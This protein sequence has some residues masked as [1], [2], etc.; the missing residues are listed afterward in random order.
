MNDSINYG[1]M[2]YPETPVNLPANQ[3]KAEYGSD[4]MADMLSAMGFKHIFLLPGSSFRGLH[5]SLVNHTRNQ[6]PEMIM[7]THEAVVM[8]MAHGY[9]KASGKTSLAIIHDLVGLMTGSVGVFDA[10]CDRVPILVLGGSGPF[11]PAKRRYIDYV[12]T[13]S[14]QSDLVKNFVKWTDEPLTLQS[15]LDSFLKAAKVSATAPKGPTYICTDLGVQEGGIDDDLVIPDQTLARYQP[16]APMAPNPG[17]LENAADMILAAEMPL[18]VGGR[19]GREMRSRDPLAELA[20]LTGA[21]LMDDRHVVVFPTSH[22]QNLTGDRGM[23]AEA[24]VILAVDCADVTEA[25]DG[26]F[27]GVRGKDGQRVIEMTM[28]HVQENSWSHYGGPVSAVDLQLDCDPHLGLAQLIG[29]LKE[30]LAGDDNL[31]KRISD[32]K[33]ALAERHKTL[34]HAQQD[35]WRENW[36][37][38]P[39]ATG[40][41]VYELYHAVKD[42]PW[43]M[44]LR[45][46]RSFPEGAWEFA[47]AGDYLGGDGGGGVGYGP[48][49]MVGASL[50]LR[51]QGRFP[52]GITGDG[53]F[54][55]G[56]H[57]TW[58]ACHYQIPTLMV[59]NNNN[60]WGNDEH[61]QIRVADARG[62]PPENAWIGQRMAEPDIDFATL[63]RS[64]GAWAEGPVDD[65]NAL[66]DVFRRAVAEVDSGNVAVVDVRTML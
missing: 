27:Q 8:S 52:V 43:T 21:A 18:I 32:R 51:E 59:I 60:S 16:A 63:A 61:H 23:R 40:R 41:M 10:W 57:A 35:R 25:Y 4:V 29:V 49:G 50:A 58:T 56:S 17:A 54:L 46:N 9:A 53:D 26:Y 55:M 15:T 11:D 44:T 62:R 1:S 38:S 36:D 47:G 13:A 3:S 20:D 5:D 24:D 66:A 6:N 45:N 39:I 7:C 14:M 33:A 30:K 48:G 12:H 34:R 31:A 19:L 2:K 64:Y 28:E 37:S 22:P 42:K 65:P